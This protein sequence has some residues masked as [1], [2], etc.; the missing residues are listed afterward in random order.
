M[1]NHAESFGAMLRE[2]RTSHDPPLSQEGLAVMLGLRQPT[3]SAWETDK[4]R[5]TTPTLVR[6]ADLL[7]L[8]LSRLTKAA[9]GAG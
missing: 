4:A 2:A 1:R 7:D 6:L 9:A 8:D 5:P 3:V